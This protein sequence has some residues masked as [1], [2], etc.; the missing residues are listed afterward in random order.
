MKPILYTRNLKCDKFMIYLLMKQLNL[1]TLAS[2]IKHQY[3]LKTISQELMTFRKELQDS[4][5]INS[6]YIP[7]TIPQ[8]IFEIR[9]A[10]VR[11]CYR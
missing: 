6:A 1:F 7:P 4:R 5:L 2:T 3:P 9:Q 8:I 10:G 11:T